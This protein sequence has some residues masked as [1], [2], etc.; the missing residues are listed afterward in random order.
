MG[1][2]VFALRGIIQFDENDMCNGYGSDI[3]E[4]ILS[5]P[6]L[7]WT[8]D[9]AK[10]AAEKWLNDDL[11]QEEG[12]T[13]PPIVWREPSLEIKKWRN[14]PNSPQQWTG[15]SEVVPGENNGNSWFRIAEFEI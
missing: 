4:D 8:L 13:P 7:F 11:G 10:K 6:Q 1:T 5:P 2:K 12:I 14:T 9:D 15:C 3:I